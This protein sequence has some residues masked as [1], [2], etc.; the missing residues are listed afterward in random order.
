MGYRGHVDFVDDNLI[1]NQNVRIGALNANENPKEVGVAHHHEKL[2]VIGQIQRRLGGELKRVAAFLL[3]GDQVRKELLHRLFV[4]NQIVVDEIHMSTRKKQN[5][6]RDIAKSV[7]TIY[8]AG[9]FVVG[10]FI[11]GFDEEKSTLSETMIE[12]IEEAS[13]PVCMV[14]LLYALPNTQLTR[15]RAPTRT[16]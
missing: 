6:K 11:V 1:G 14:G 7:Q 10:G 13:I 2:G 5:T 4:A 15:R 3:P 8:E 9:V 12:L 16:F